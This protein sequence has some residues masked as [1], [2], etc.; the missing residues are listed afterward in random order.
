M[1]KALILVS[2]NLGAHV[3]AYSEMFDRTTEVGR[4]SGAKAAAEVWAYDPHQGPQREAARPKVLQIIEDNV[5]RFRYLENYRPVEQLSSS[6]V[7]RSE[8]LSEIKIPTLIIV[9]AHDNIVARTNYQNWANG[10]AGATMIM[11]P[12]SGHLVPID[13]PDEFNQAVLEYLNNL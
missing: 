13:Q 11:F 1:V 10:I 8:R 12:D 4:Q 6:D 2:S 5:T 3:P 7:P 9:G